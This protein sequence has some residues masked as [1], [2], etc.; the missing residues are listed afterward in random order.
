[1]SELIVEPPEVV[2]LEFGMVLG[3]AAAPLFMLGIGFAMAGAPPGVP[4][5]PIGVPCVLCCPA[6]TGALLDL[7]IAAPCA[8]AVPIS[9]NV[10]TP[11]SRPLIFIDTV[12]ATPFDS[13]GFTVATASA[14]PSIKN[15]AGCSVSSRRHTLSDGTCGCQRWATA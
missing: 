4:V 3:A 12:I 10:A 14:D 11:A 5:V 7:S 1:M 2:M 15:C 8:M 9:A 6:P 13:S